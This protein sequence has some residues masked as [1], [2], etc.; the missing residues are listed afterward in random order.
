MNRSDEIIPWVHRREFT[1]PIF[2]SGNV[3]DLKAQPDRERRVIA[4]CVAHFLDVFT[5]LVEAHPP[6]VEI[7][8]PHR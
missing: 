6:I 2:V 3:I 5:E 8:A 4:L 1:N 7:I